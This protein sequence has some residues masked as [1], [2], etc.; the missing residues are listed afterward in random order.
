M[1]Q[2]KNAVQVR[3]KHKE[4]SHLLK[5][6]PIGIG[7][8]IETMFICT[9]LSATFTIAIA[10]DCTGL[11]SLSFRPSSGRNFPS[12]NFCKIITARG[13]GLELLAVT[14]FYASEVVVAAIAEHYRNLR[15]FKMEFSEILTSLEPLWNSVG[16]K[17]L[18]LGI[19]RD[20]YNSMLSLSVLF[21]KLF[22]DSSV[23]LYFPKTLGFYA[24]L[25]NCSDLRKLSFESEDTR[26]AQ[27]FCTIISAFGPA[28]QSLSVLNLPASESVMRHIVEHCPNLHQISMSWTNALEILAPLRNLPA[29]CPFVSCFSFSFTDRRDWEPLKMF[30]NS[31]DRNLWS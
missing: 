27:S 18:N 8:G 5:A 29:L 15:H 11:R 24:T 3:G 10:K 22:I 9:L 25:E 4:V 13:S 23:V 17:L 16:E 20:E 6:L 1:K 28:L 21:T 12:A 30:A 7:E 19:M 31:S 14:D 2:K 26:S